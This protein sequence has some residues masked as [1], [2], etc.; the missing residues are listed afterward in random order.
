MKTKNIWIQ[1]LKGLREIVL[2]LLKGKI[3]LMILKFNNS[4][5][6]K[7]CLYILMDLLLIDLSNN[8]LNLSCLPNRLSNTC[9]LNLK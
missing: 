4:K 8:N 3:L 9:Q 2:A 6:N 7:M 5:Y 1:L